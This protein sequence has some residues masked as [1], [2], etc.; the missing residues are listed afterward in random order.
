MAGCGPF[1]QAT[2]E[3]KRPGHSFSSFGREKPEE[4]SGGE[5][6]DEDEDEDEEE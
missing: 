4:E 2:V 5:E 1:S 6:E 3:R